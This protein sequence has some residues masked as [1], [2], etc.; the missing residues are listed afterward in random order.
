[1]KSLSDIAGSVPTP[2]T[3]VIYDWENRWA[4]E[5]MAG[6]AKQGLAPLIESSSQ[7]SAA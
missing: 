7:N 4:I 5:D 3:A 2:K 1:M 6:G